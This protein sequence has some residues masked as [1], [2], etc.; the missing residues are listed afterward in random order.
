VTRLLRA[1]SKRK[2]VSVLFAG[3]QDSQTSADATIDTL[4]KVLG[5]Q[6][7]LQ[8]AVLVGSRATGVVHAQSDWDIALQWSPQLDWLEVLSKTEALRNTL[9]EAMHIAPSAIDLIELRRAN[10]AMR[11][12]VT[13]EGIPLVGQNSVAWM[14]FLQHTWRELENFYWEKHHAA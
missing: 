1:T 13:E 12:S 9:A 11:A 3:C 5:E 14:H 7:K 4:V 10:L 8:F 2:T 6:P